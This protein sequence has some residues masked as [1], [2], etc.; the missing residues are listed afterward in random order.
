[1]LSQVT[2][3]ID[4]EMRP[5][6]GLETSSARAEPFATERPKSF[7]CYMDRGESLKSCLYLTYFTKRLIF[8]TLQTRA[9]FTG[10]CRKFKSNLLMKRA[11]FLLNFAFATFL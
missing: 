3:S 4:R 1:M 6:T 10:F 9:D 7:Q 11:L 5:T 8:I 2:H